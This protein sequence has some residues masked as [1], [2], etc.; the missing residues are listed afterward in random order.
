MAGISLDIVKA[1]L[2][3][4]LEVLRQRDFRFLWIG[5]FSS[6]LGDQFYWIALP[7]LI[8]QLTGDPL[9]MGSLLAVQMVPRSLFML[10]GGALTDR[11]SPRSVM[12]A[13]V[14]LRLVLVGVLS[15]LVL[16]GLVH[17]WMLYVLA[18]LFG[19]VDGFFFP[20]Q[21]SIVP[22]LLDHKDLRSGNALIQGTAQMSLFLGPMVAG[23]LIAW[24]DGP[25][26]V[27]HNGVLVEDLQGIGIAFAIDMVGYI[28][29]SIMLSQITSRKPVAHTEDENEQMNVLESIRSGLHYAWRNL[30]LR[31]FFFIVAMMSFIVNGAITVGVPVLADTRFHEGAAAFGIIM[32]SFGGGSLLG[33]LLASTL[34]APPPRRVG[35][36]LLLV[37]SGLGIGLILL[38]FTSVMLFA[39]LIA[40]ATGV[41][42]GYV[43]ITVITW[44][45]R[46]TPPMMLG[47]TMS[48]LTFSTVG[49]SPI[50]I[51]LAGVMI[52]WNDTVFLALAGSLLALVALVTAFSPAGK[53]MEG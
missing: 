11:F 15:A 32:S 41:G 47:R 36:I 12:L 17:L 28:V 44:L 35:R 16:T 3:S 50:A 34:P 2:S 42:A 18:L 1:R 37:S 38:S 26:K 31:I 53:F 6:L 51:S 39:A 22:A 29:A 10:V 46:R 48:L 33:L 25:N 20:A 13:S 49:L 5:E 40:L 43:L 27:I 23:G 45:Q 52:K 30:D 24:L 9:V 14:I 7:W 8:L 4:P 21:N 19:L